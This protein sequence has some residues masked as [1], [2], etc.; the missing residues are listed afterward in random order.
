MREEILRQYFA[1]NLPVT[2]LGENLCGSV[3][4]LGI[5][6]RIAIEDMQEDFLVGREHILML[7]DAFLQSTLDAEGLNTIAFARLASDRFELDGDDEPLLEVLHDWS[8][9]EIQFPPE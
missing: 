3:T 1:G 6:S 8:G 2:A 4:R 9:P 7:G 5:S